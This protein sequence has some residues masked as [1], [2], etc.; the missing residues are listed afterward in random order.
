[1]PVQCTCRHCGASFA[2]PPS[3]CKAGVPPYCGAACYHASRVRPGKGPWTCTRCGECKPIE[4]FP[5]H[6]GRRDTFCRVCQ[7]AQR[8]SAYGAIVETKR[9]AM[10]AYYAKHKAAKLAHDKLYH[11]AHPEVARRAVA[12][13]RERYPEKAAAHA[14]VTSAI[15]S[16]RLVRQSCS[17]CGNVKSEAH[18]YLGYAVE[19][20]LSVTWLCRFHHLRAH[21]LLHGS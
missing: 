20:I 3:R 5:L 8:R 11:T 21:K 14:A 13:Y 9:R 18:H 15:Q 6:G 16:G 10:Q 4:D 1:M 7:R 17:E 19:H 12:A 2:V